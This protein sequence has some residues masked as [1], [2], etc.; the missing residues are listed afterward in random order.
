MADRP[1]TLH[2][3]LHGAHLATLQQ[4]RQGEPIRLAHTEQA[5]DTYPGNSPVISNSLRVSRRAQDATAWLD[6]LLPEGPLRDVIAGNR[7]VVSSDTWGMIASLGRDVAGAC[8]IVDPDRP[9]GDRQPHVE[10]YPT[11]DHVAAAVDALPETPL[12]VLDDSELSLAGMQDKLLLVRTDA[13]CGWGRPVGGYPST[14]ILKVDPARAALEG[15]V[16]HEAAA[17]AVA[18]RAGL[19]T[20]APTI[21]HHADGSWLIVERYDR[22]VDGS[23]G[24]TRIHQE[25][26]AQAAGIDARRNRRRAKYESHGGPGLLTAARL[27]R[28]GAQ[29]VDE[30]L[31]L[32]VGAMVFTVLIGNSDAHAKNLSLVLD[33][34]GA[35]QL[36]PLYDTVPTMLFPTL[37]VRCAMMIGGVHDD[38]ELVD[39]R[40]LVYEIE[41]RR[42][43]GITSDR[44]G[45]LVD[46]WIDRVVQ[47]SVDDRV[48]EYI[49]R[50]ADRLAP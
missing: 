4:L 14:H 32:L 17:L 1:T 3:H 43:W 46:E 20:I 45:A 19:T 23:G 47:A 15:V 38:L 49:R 31:W 25:D 11:L 30:Q 40:A 34:P 2:L 28:D 22:S 33:P 5:L 24:V 50:R 48:G 21:V 6:G 42:R 16:E 39:R 36:A 44:A 27:L 35:V 10:P 7:G 8:I 26:L 41:G 18:Q 29:D 9:V 37:A 12:G 13:G